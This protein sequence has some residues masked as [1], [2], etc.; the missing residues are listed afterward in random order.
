[1]AGRRQL[2]AQGQPAHLAALVLCEVLTSDRQTRLGAGEEAAVSREFLG[3][4][5]RLVKRGAEALVRRLHAHLGALG[6]VLPGAA[7]VL[8]EVLAQAG[9]AA[10][11]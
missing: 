11:A 2:Q 5:R 8:G 6:E 4:F 1:M 3:L 10:V 7:G 9:E